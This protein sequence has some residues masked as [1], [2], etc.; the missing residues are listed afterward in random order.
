MIDSGECGERPTDQV[1]PGATCREFR[2][3]QEVGKFPTDDAHDFADIG[4]GEGTHRC[5]GGRRPWDHAWVRGLRTR[6]VA[7]I[8]A[9]ART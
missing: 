3:V 8:V 6:S 7:S 9:E 1:R 5:R 2:K 4:A